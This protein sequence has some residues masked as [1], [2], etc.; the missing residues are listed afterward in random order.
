MSTFLDER[1]HIYRS[2]LMC[3]Y[4]YILTIKISRIIDKYL[5]FLHIQ[6][7]KKIYQYKIEKNVK[8]LAYLHMEKQVTF[9]CP[10]S[11]SSAPHVYKQIKNKKTF[12]VFHHKKY[13]N[14]CRKSESNIK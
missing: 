10:E 3:I 6:K 4:V 8:Y 7:E 1:A 11:S 12:S 5:I 14:F 9:T 13:L 2:S